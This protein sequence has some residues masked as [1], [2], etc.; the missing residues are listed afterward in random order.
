MALYA[1]RADLDAKPWARDI[2]TLADLGGDNVEDAGLVDGILASASA[3]VESKVAG[4]TDLGLSAPYPAKLVD[5]TC[6]IARY[7]LYVDEPPERVTKRY[8][9]AI[10]LLI[11]VRD[12]LES[13]GLDAQ[14]RAVET[15]MLVEIESQGNV[16][17]RRDGTV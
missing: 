4:R 14:G 15:P 10:K 5:V 12:G 7:L 17:G 11:A 2:P 1:T 16:F 9:D 8:N 3:E 13:F 6:D